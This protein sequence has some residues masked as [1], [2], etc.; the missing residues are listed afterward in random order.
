MCNEEGSGGGEGWI[1]GILYATLGGDVT[2]GEGSWGGEERRRGR[3]G[4]F[5]ALQREAC[6]LVPMGTTRVGFGTGGIFCGSKKCKLHAFTNFYSDD[7]V[8]NLD[9]CLCLDSLLYEIS[10]LDTCPDSLL[11]YRTQGVSVCYTLS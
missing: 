9:I 10:Y 7:V 5:L 8:V 4:I 11:Y 2:G 1:W 6:C 3:L